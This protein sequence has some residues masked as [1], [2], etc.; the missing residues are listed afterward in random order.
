MPPP[1]LVVG[2]ACVDMVARMPPVGGPG[3]DATLPQISGGGTGANTAVA[4]ARLGVPVVFVGAVGQD[5]HGRQV[6]REL[7]AEGVDVSRVVELPDAPTALV[8][9]VI[10][11]DGERTIFGSP[12]P[13]PAHSRLGA[14]HVDDELIT[15]AAW[16][17]TTGMCLLQAPSS[18]TVLY[19]LQRARDERIPCSLDLNLRGGLTEDGLSRSFGDTLWN[20]VERSDFV[21]GSAIDEIPYMVPARSMEEAARRLAG[22]DRTVVARRGADGA[23]LVTATERQE[24]PSFPV[25]VVDTLGAGDA[26]DAGFIAARL[27]GRDTVEAIRWGHAV[28]ALSTSRAGARGT[29]SATEA[30]ALLHS[31]SRT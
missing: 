19:C 30:R 3:S 6:R 5:G 9:A 11:R 28:A 1:V 2:D 15:G 13:R 22:A 29:P 17:H 7:G 20:A 14:E 23:T 25:D 24:I 31:R 21:L 12:W 18:E 10:D 4:L 27:D 8:L 16:V 26:F